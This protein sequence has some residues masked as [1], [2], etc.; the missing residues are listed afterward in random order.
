MT[1]EEK[2]PNPDEMALFE[3]TYKEPVPEVCF[4]F[5]ESIETMNFQTT[6]PS[7]NLVENCLENFRISKNHLAAKVYSHQRF[8]L[9]FINVRLKMNLS[10]CRLSRAIGNLKI[11]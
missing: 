7:S 3:S 2:S 4:N 5:N 6:Y 1:S 9:I 8:S 10:V 11:N